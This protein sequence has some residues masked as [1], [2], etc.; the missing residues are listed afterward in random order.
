ML[1]RGITDH[2]FVDVRVLGYTSSCPDDTNDV[3]KP[4]YKVRIMDPSVPIEEKTRIVLTA[5]VHG[6]E[7]LT[8]FLIEA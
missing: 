7:R 5:R 1:S 8:S 2:P 6:G 3:A 4:V